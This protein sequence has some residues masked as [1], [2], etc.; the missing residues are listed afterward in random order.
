MRGFFRTKVLLF[1][2]AVKVKL[3]I[4]ANAIIKCLWNWL[5]ISLYYRVFFWLIWDAHNLVIFWAKNKFNSLTFSTSTYRSHFVKK[6]SAK[7]FKTLNFIT[8][9]V[10]VT[11]FRKKSYFENDQYVKEAKI[12]KKKHF[13]I[14]YSFKYHLYWPCILI[15][16]YF[17][18]TYISFL[19][20]PIKSLIHLKIK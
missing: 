19:S 2:L 12:D 15:S 4:G 3:F 1:V 10:K 18:I 16:R 7:I 5:L 6:I 9:F 20:F 14:C 13:C 8:D 11:I 17:L